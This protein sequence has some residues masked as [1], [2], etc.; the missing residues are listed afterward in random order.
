ME[1]E[2]ILMIGLPLAGKTTY[3]KDLITR[4]PY[5]VVEG[6][7]IM[8]SLRS[9]GVDATNQNMD[10][11]YEV[12]RIMAKAFMFREFPVIIDDRNLLVES[13]FLWR[14]VAE[15]HG[16]KTVGIILD[17][18][19]EICL[20]RSEV[21]SRGDAMYGHIKQCSEQLDE[22]KTVLGLKHQSILSN[23]RVINTEAT[24]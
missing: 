16:Y 2:L 21:G 8:K 17:T 9:Q 14:Q 11:V 6:R 12:E 22:L 18:P 5:Q 4:V 13:I 19:I 10:P 24:K 3:V 7:C 15:T 23:Y 20:K 1:K